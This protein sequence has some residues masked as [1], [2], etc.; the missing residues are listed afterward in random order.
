[1][2]LSS[3]NVIQARQ[4]PDKKNKEF[5]TA[6]T[7]QPSVE[8]TSLRTIVLINII[9]ARQTPDKKHKKILYSNG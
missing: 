4:T 3:I 8:V 6:M 2:R 9:Q 1:M 5:H 7:R